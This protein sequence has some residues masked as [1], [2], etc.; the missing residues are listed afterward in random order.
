MG[1]PKQQVVTY[2]A[3]QTAHG[4]AGASN[5]PEKEAFLSRQVVSGVSGSDRSP[6]GY[7]SSQNIIYVRTLKGAGRI[8][9]QPCIDTYSKVA[10]KAA[11]DE[12]TNCSS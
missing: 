2:A 1:S 12:N 5:A 3:E 11:P 9:Q 4:Q 8:N 7:L 6:P 10:C